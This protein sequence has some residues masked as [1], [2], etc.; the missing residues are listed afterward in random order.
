MPSISNDSSTKELDLP[1]VEVLL[2]TFNGELYLSEFLDSLLQQQGVRIHLRVSDDGSTD[3][4]LN[5]IESYKNRFASCKI[6]LGPCE[7][8]S[9]NFFSLIQQSTYEFVALADQDD[10]WDKRRLIN[11]LE[12]LINFDGPALSFSSSIEFDTN[13]P[14]NQRI[15]PGNLNIKS[16]NSIIFQNCARGSTMSMNRK[17][18]ELINVFEHKAAVMHDWWCL[19][20]IYTCGQVFYSEKPQIFYRIHENNH[21]GVGKRKKL[22]SIRT[23]WSGVWNVFNQAEELFTHFAGHMQKLQKEE[24]IKILDLKKHNWQKR[25]HFILFE[26]KTPFRNNCKDEFRLRIGLFFIKFINRNS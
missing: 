16:L 10:I 3:G 13:N 1:E 22:Q 17:A 19:L 2:A 26:I 11:S 14:E 5:I 15:W 20:V 18:Y 6:L 23:V 4:T 8:P 7:G 25:A 12:R 21:V 24:L 9:E